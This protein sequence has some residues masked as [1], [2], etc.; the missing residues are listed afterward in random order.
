MHELIGRLVSKLGVDESTAEQV[1]GI[2]LRALQSEGPADGVANL[3]SAFPGAEDMIAKAGEDS[4]GSGG[5]LSSVLAPLGGGGLLME[6]F[7]KLQSVGLNMDQSKTAAYE[8]VGYARETVGAD[9]V[10][11]VLDEIP[12]LKGFV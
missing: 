3:L 10:D 2:I 6:T 8:V 1:V 4:G 9:V 7:G 11:G 5:F 12:A